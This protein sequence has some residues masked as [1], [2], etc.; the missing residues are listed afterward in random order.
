M[1]PDRTGAASE[2]ENGYAG[3]DLSGLQQERGTGIDSAS[4]EDPGT[5]LEADACLP[6][7]EYMLDWIRSRGACSRWYRSSGLVKAAL[8]RSDADL[9]Y[10]LEPLPCVLHERVGAMPAM[11]LV[12]EGSR[13]C[14]SLRNE[15]NGVADRCIAQE[16]RGNQERRVKRSPIG[17]AKRCGEARVNPDAPMARGE[18]EFDDQ[19]DG[20]AQRG[21]RRTVFGG[22]QRPCG[23]VV[24]K[25]QESR[26]GCDTRKAVQERGVVQVGL[27]CC[28]SSLAPCSGDCGCW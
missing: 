22:P 17:G 5:E 13:G 20:R 3:R 8:M 23:I 19:V 21:D 6:N 16:K 2:V 18:V 11:R 26:L 24:A 12:E 27:W 1:D 14:E 15:V 7:S 10:A 25:V 4:S 9:V 28:H